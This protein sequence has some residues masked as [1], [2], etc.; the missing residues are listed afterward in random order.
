[1]PSVDD[2]VSGNI[3]RMLKTGFRLFDRFRIP[4]LGML[5][6]KPVKAELKKCAPQKVS[7][8]QVRT[9][10]Q[11]ADRCAVG[12]RVCNALYKGAD[13]GES[14]FLDELAEGLVQA[15]KAHYTD[16]ASAVKAILEGRRGPI[17]ITRVS[18]KYMEICRTIAKNCF[19]WN[20]E[21]HGLKCIQRQA[22]N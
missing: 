1:M 4:I 2:Y 22:K 3:L 18:G 11:K 21:K 13:L 12:Q 9:L 5:A 20:S 7:A 16:K 15:G 17:V 14:V 8:D 19:Y 10:I 6:K